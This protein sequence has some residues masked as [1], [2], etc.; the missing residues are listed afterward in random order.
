VIED[1][2]GRSQFCR[3]E[4]HRQERAQRRKKP[5]SLGSKPRL[6]RCTLYVLT[7]CSHEKIMT[8]LIIQQVYS[9]IQ[10][11]R[12]AWKQVKQVKPLRE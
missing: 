2:S 9:E 3:S 12:N 10:N 8:E 1:S 6:L 7:F 11:G 4:R 5:Q